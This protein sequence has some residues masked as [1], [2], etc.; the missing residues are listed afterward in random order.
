[1]KHNKKNK[2]KKLLD[3]HGAENADRI[4]KPSYKNQINSIMWNVTFVIF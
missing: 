1:M 2:L 4:S 3:F